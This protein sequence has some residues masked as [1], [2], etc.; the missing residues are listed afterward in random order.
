MLTKR[1]L[2]ENDYDYMVDFIIDLD[3]I[4]INFVYLILDALEIYKIYKLCIFVCNKYKLTQRIG[5]YLL[6]IAHIYS[7]ISNKEGL[8]YGHISEDG[9]QR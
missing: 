3:L 6:S 9:V 1:N 7:T 4:D 5:R 8:Y 2:T